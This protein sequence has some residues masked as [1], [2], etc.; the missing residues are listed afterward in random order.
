M[1]K[2]KSRNS[3]EKIQ[4]KRKLKREAHD[5]VGKAMSYIDEGRKKK[6]DG[7]KA[8]NIMEVETRNKLI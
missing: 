3:K 6:H 8:G 7:L 2:D 5:A 1:R 4:K